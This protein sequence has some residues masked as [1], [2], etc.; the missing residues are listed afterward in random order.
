MRL[1]FKMA[2]IGL[3]LLLLLIPLALLDDLVMERKQRGLEVAAEISRSSG[4]AQT[5]IGP[6][7]LI[8]QV[9]TSEKIETVS[10]AGVLRQISRQEQTREQRVQLPDRL[11]MQAELATQQ[12]A[13]G[14]FAALLYRGTHAIEAEFAPIEV[15]A[16][17]V[18]ESVRVA[19]AVSDARGIRAV[20]ARMGTAALQLLPG[21]QLAWQ[22]AG[23]HAELAAETLAN[24]W[25]VHIELDLAGAGAW[26]WLPAAEQSEL[27]VRSNWPHPSFQGGFLPDAP[28]IDNE[29]FEASWQI[30]PFAGVVGEALRRCLPAQSHCAADF[31][32]ALGFRLVEPV[33]RY[34]MTDR[35]LKYALLFLALVFGVVF[36]IEITAG[37][38]MHPMQ[39]ALVGLALA[40]FYLLL[41]ALAEHLGFAWAYAL[42]ASACS[43]LI[44]VY[45][46]GTL[47]SG[48][49][50]M[51]LG[52]LLPVLY[53]LLYGILQSE[54]LALLLGSCV[55]FGLLA[56]V[57]LATRQVD[58]NSVGSQVM[59]RR[60]DQA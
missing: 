20:T 59:A 30:S 10:E 47:G 51:L 12:R 48:R 32:Q 49:R 31:G 19:M 7:L 15:E 9:R 45:L 21:S 14:P 6:L 57:M 36:F 2:W 41:L 52:L 26:H 50:G 54:D 38:R 39:Y 29:G 43:A 13:R 1:A 34:L 17:T 44:L 5:L 24:R 11:R 60:G 8:E 46:W 16:G 53:A 33:D 35:A 56:V 37:V 42:A 25:A 28:M 40:I 27:Q 55:L 4:G 18:V 58:W 22:P 23:M 3:L